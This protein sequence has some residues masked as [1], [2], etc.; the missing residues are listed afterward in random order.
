MKVWELALVI[1]AVTYSIVN[2]VVLGIC[3]KL[4]TKL[5]GFV[6]KAF[7]ISE[8]MMSKYEKELDDDEN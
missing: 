4:A 5:D 8:K 6:D 2:F 7:K 1:F 3:L